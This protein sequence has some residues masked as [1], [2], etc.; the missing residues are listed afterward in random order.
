MTDTTY[1]QDHTAIVAIL[2]KYIEGCAKPDGSVMRPAFSEQ[3]TIFGVEDGKLSGGPIEGLFSTIDTAFRPSPEARAVI[4]QVDIVG[5]A[6]SARVDT[7]NV[8]GFC[9]TD[10]FHLMKVGGEWTIVSK[11]FHTHSGT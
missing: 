10:F 11:I 6:A 4:A 1:V 2:N 8:S 7:D 5:T 3:A 9:F